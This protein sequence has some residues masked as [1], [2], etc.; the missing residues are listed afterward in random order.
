[1]TDPIISYTLKEAQALE[2]EMAALQDSN[3]KLS[4]ELATAKT[5][6]EKV[7]GLDKIAEALADVMVSGKLISADKVAETKVALAKDGGI[8]TYF[9]KA[10]ELYRSAEAGRKEA[11]ERLKEVPARI[12]R[13]HG[14][15]VAGE[16]AERKAPESAIKVASDKFAARVLAG[17]R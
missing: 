9:K 17:G 1:M 11:I 14:E 5:A 6:A 13:Q 16:H 12:G 2:A 8:A 4:A 3:T 10:C 15:K 7:A